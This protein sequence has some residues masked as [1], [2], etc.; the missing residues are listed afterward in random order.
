[1][2]IIIL[3]SLK[4]HDNPLVCYDKEG[5]FL[6]GSEKMVEKDSLDIEFMPVLVNDDGSP[7]NDANLYLIYRCEKKH[8]INHTT[9][10]S[11]ARSLKIFFEWCKEEEID[12]RTAPSPLRVPT[13][14]FK[15]FLLDQMD[16][17][18]IEKPWSKNYAKKLMTDIVGFYRWLTSD[19]NVTFEHPLY[20]ETQVWVT[21]NNRYGQSTGREVTT[22]DVVKIYP[23]QNNKD[24]TDPTIT[25]GK[26]LRPMSRDEQLKFIEVINEVAIEYKL[27]C[28]ISL[29]TS[30]RLQTVCTLRLINFQK[31]TKGM[32]E[33]MEVSFK[34]GYGT[35]VDTKFNK[36]FMLYF[37]VWLY[38]QIQT[39][40]ESERAKKRRDKADTFENELHHYLFLTNRGSPW[41]L[42]KNDPNR[43]NYT[44][45]PT[46]IVVSQYLINYV[47][48]H[49]THRFKFH[50]LRATYGINW[51]DGHSD[52]YGNIYDESRVLADLMERMAHENSDTTYGYLN[53]RKDIKRMANI[54]D[55][56]EIELKNAFK[57]L[58]N[59]KNI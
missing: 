5:Q 35:L 8:N 55:S 53:Y 38:R 44:R 26:E 48:P 12:Y 14:L 19:G 25:D 43:E 18:F 34:V 54:Q 17:L 15:Q 47:K 4:I 57:G 45:P 51:V 40:L 30:A 41:Y 22:T 37:P 56:Y 9:L 29:L 10:E 59:V 31:D 39:Y 11:I 58:L 33:D 3:K 42:A 16:P 50:D 7:Q 20:Q 27:M 49:L 24:Y 13:Y 32:D 46:G 21:Y 2:K 52:A 6:E 23:Q 1:M 36:S 28:L